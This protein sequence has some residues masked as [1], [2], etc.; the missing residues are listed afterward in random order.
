MALPKHEHCRS[1]CLAGNMRGFI[2]PSGTGR[3]P[4]LL[5][6]EGGGATEEKQGKPF[7]GE[8]GQVLERALRAAGLNRNDYTITNLLS[9]R[10]P[11]NELRGATYEHEALA[12][13]RPLLNATVAE[14]Q[15]RLILALGDLPLR[16][17]AA[18][19]GS[20]SELRGF[21][22][23]SIYGCKLIAT[24]HPSYL[25]P[26]RGQ[27]GTQHLFGAFM[28]DIRRAAQIAK[29][30]L[31]E[32][33][34]TN[35]NLNPTEADLRDYIERLRSN[36]DLHCSH[37]L[38]TEDI[39]RP[40]KADIRSKRIIQIQ[41]SSGIGEAIVVPWTERW[42]E[43]IKAVFETSNPKWGF[44]DRLFDRP[45]LRANG[46]TLNGELHDLINLYAHLQSNFV[47]GKDDTAGDK[48]VPSRLMSLQSC[49]SFHYP[50]FRPWK[51]PYMPPFEPRWEGQQLPLPLRWYGAKDADATTRVG[52]RMFDA[53]RRTGLESGYR[54]FKWQ[55][56]FVLDDLSERGLPVDAEAQKALRAHIEVEEARLSEQL[57]TLVPDELRPT[58]QYKSLPRDLRAA[59]KEQGCKPPKSAV[60]F[61]ERAVQ[62]ATTM[63]FE[64]RDSVLHR[65]LAFNP[66]SSQQLLGYIRYRGYPVP[67]HIDSQQPTTG[68]DAIT[69]LAET[70]HDELLLA[71]QQARKLTKLKGVYTGKDWTPGDDGRVHAEFRFGSASGQISSTRP[72]VQQFVQHY[73]PKITWEADLVRRAK[74]MIR[75]PEGH[76]LVKTDM[77]GFHS[78]GI[79]FLADDPLYYRASL[80]DVHSLVCAHFLRLPIA[81]KLLD[82]ADDE[83]D[84]QLAAIKKEHKYTR[85]YKVKRAV[86]GMQFLLQAPKLYVMNADV[87]ESVTEAMFLMDTI[88]NLFPLTFHEFPK[89]IEA[90]LRKQ[91]WL[92]SPFGHRRFFWDADEEQATAYLPSNICHC[93]I[94]AAMIR[95]FDKGMFAR[96]AATN[97]LHDAV[98]WLPKAKDVDECIVEAKRELER[99][100]EVL[101]SPI[102]GAFYCPADAEVGDDLNSCKA[103]SV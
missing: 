78:R 64:I 70:T 59:L 30:G 91:P 22:L 65:V 7:V 102:L 17:L 33:T 54:T 60:G 63:S 99:P 45:I 76:K 12:H 103:Y 51:H 20:I 39:L 55:L 1:C 67:L 74:S 5:V 23:D 28:H 37:D 85:D 34:P 32:P 72:N 89:K 25:L 16:E 49:I 36:R 46:I 24:Y 98:W 40:T 75:A 90:A 2:L 53:L 6:G 84:E 8:S 27:P 94:Q 79:A 87:F 41:F 15:P 4:L 42:I 83:L 43:G 44:N 3:I 50:D 62:L 31:P 93:T 81:D 101:V 82:M 77:R 35:Y 19:K 100:S 86:H 61:C 21:L 48:G 58:Q 80:H 69:K 66:N 97:F 14:R 18:T 29:S 52:L 71:V 13:C 26:R 56:S 9:C 57:Q 38:E 68:R 88:R 96:F 92:V 10:P 73:N 11:K 95:L 47:S